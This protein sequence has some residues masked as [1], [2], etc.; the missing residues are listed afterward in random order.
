MMA[1][2]RSGSRTTGMV[3]VVMSMGIHLPGKVQAGRCRVR[4]G[5]GKDLVSIVGRRPQ[6]E[7]LED[8]G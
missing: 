4:V 1:N 2:C 5:G 6:V 8:G 3:R 7:V